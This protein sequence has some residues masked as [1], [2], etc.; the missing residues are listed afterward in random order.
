[1]IHTHGER[2]LS[3]EKQCYLGWVTVNKAVQ[4]W[5]QGCGTRHITNLLESIRTLVEYL[6]Q[7]TKLPPRS[8][9]PSPLPLIISLN[10]TASFLF[11]TSVL[12]FSFASQGSFCNCL[13]SL[14]VR[15]ISSCS[16]TISRFCTN[17]SKLAH[18]LVFCLPKENKH[19]RL[20]LINQ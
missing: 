12:M 1:M 4:L 15:G 17:W 14:W 3:R 2:R 11:I 16:F 8:Q 6:S 5:S 13:K 20:C 19:F 18:F 9:K 10:Y 7:N